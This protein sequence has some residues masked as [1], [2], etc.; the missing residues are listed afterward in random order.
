[1]LAASIFIVLL[2]FHYLASDTAS[3]P[4]RFESSYEP[5]FTSVKATN[6]TR[7]GTK[8][9]NVKYYYLLFTYTLVVLH[10]HCQSQWPYS[11]T[12][13]SV[14]LDYWDHMFKSC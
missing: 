5:Y 13:I 12:Y 7:H 6:Q 9:K 11:L 2:A 8:Y 4:G 14:A 3:Y 10:M 1:M